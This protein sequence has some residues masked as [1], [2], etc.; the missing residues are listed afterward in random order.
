M[1][2]NISSIRKL[3]IQK[4]I[5]ENNKFNSPLINIINTRNTLSKN[6]K[7]IKRT[8]CPIK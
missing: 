4:T 3:K 6:N 1:K 2:N 7:R 8:K 5:F